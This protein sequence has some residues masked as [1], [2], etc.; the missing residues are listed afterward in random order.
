[1]S[2]RNGQV[3]GVVLAAGSSSR[4]GGN[5]L[6]LELDGESV[7]RRAVR[8]A[9]A[10]GLD[11]VLVVLGHDA[12]RVSLELADLPCR[13]VRNADHVLGPGTSIRAGVAAAPSEAEAIV[14]TLA[15]MPFVTASTIRAVVETYRAGAA[16]VVVCRYG[17][18]E[19][20]PTLFDRSLFPELAAIE[21]D[22][23]ARQ[24]A[25][26]HEGEAAR[27]EW[28]GEDGLDL[29]VAADY[30]CARA[31]LARGEGGASSG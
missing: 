14:F 11:A 26:R 4:M 18:T 3:A 24:I 6:L 23:G 30:E 15:D 22:R 19:A 21:A 27:V 17:A 25:R 9:L 12:D 1:M 20:P 8:A 29:D 7:V 31:R 13:D 28:P 2:T 5:K 10:A 16:R